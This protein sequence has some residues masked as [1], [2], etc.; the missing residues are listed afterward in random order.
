M[1]PIT[2][3][4][5]ETNAHPQT[6]MMFWF[7]FG[8]SRGALTRTKILNLLQRQPS[9]AN[10]ISQKIDLDYKAIKHHLETLEKNNL[11]G[12]FEVGYGAT[13]FVTNLFEENKT[14]FDEII[15][16]LNFKN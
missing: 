2:V 6:K 15:T 9:N 13:Y 16:K 11:I 1:K 8:S 10:Q 3:K 12:K 7:L 4:N 5:I 14:I